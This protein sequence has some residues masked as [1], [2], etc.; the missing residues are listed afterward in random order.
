MLLILPYVEQEAIFK[1]YSSWG[2]GSVNSRDVPH[3][4]NVALCPSDKPVKP[5]GQTYNGSSYHNYA[6][7]FGNTAVGDTATVMI[8]LTTFN[9][10]TFAGAP[11]GYTTAKRID[12]ITDGT[13]NTLMLAEV[14]Q[15]QG[16]DVRG[17]TWW[18]DGASFSTGLKP[19]DSAADVVSHTY[20]SAAAPNPPANCAG[21][22][23]VVSGTTYLVRQFAARSRHTGGVSVVLCDGSVRFVPNSV[24][25][26]VWQ[27][28]GTSQGGEVVGNF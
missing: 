23:V 26:V 9:S 17:F 10:L 22:S 8:T 18:G 25:P 24:D 11:F 20:R 7:S 28:L 6:A 21:T 3:Q 2:N 4:I 15:G 12:D 13:S 1:L 27:Y 5:G 16:Q 14:I 19:N